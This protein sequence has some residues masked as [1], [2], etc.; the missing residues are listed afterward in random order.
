MIFSTLRRTVGLSTL[1]GLDVAA[2]E[3]MTGQPS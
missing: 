2:D 1:T 3:S